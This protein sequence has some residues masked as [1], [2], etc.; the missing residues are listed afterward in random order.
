MEYV[1]LCCYCSIYCQLTSFFVRTFSNHTIF[2][3]LPLVV[4]VR[5]MLSMCCRFPLLSQWKHF[6]HCSICVV[7]FWPNSKFFSSPWL[8]HN[9]ILKLRIHLSTTGLVRLYLMDLE[10]W[11]LPEQLEVQINNIV[12]KGHAFLA[13]YK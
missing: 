2:K 9:A 4:N 10:Q 11:S 13:F 8:L 6:T 7:L 12:G 5:K 3:S 1:V